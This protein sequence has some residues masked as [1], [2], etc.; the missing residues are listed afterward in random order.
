[1][2][3]MLPVITTI[4]G[5]VVYAVSIWATYH[6]EI[7]ATRLFWVVGM[8]AAVV[9]HGVWSLLAQSLDEQKGIFLYSLLWDVGFTAVSILIPALLFGLRV[10]LPGYAGLLLIVV[11]SLVVK[12]F[13][14]EE[15]AAE[16]CASSGKMGET[17][18]E[19]CSPTPLSLGSTSF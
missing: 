3:K 1:M 10:S 18:A 5:L 17:E 11:G 2:L 13:G 12:Q 7:R 19:P 15:T 14:L 9:G 4:V 16:T 8:S 6:P